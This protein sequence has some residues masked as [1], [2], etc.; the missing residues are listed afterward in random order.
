MSELTGGDRLSPRPYSTQPSAGPSARTGSPTAAA[1]R[2]QFTNTVPGFKKLI[3]W[4]KKQG[5]QT[6][7]SLL[8]MEHTG[9]YALALCCFL[10][11]IELPYT[12]ISPWN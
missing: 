4:L 7:N 8:G 6:T 5:V 9:H 2:Q 1:A 11:Q 3:C 10:Q 12:M